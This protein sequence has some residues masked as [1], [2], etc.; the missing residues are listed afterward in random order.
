MRMLSERFMGDLV[1][2]E[3][4][5]NPILARVKKD[6]TLMIAIREN[7]INLYYRGSKLLRVTEQS[8]GS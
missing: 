6:Q 8:A 5:L 7:Y 3:G 4:L 2:Q 1:Q